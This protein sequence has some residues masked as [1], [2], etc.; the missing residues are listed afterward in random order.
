MTYD[1]LDE[2]TILVKLTQAPKRACF[3]FKLTNQVKDLVI[4]ET[5][6]EKIP[7]NV[8]LP[9]TYYRLL[10]LE[11][12]YEIKLFSASPIKVADILVIEHKFNQ[13]L[14]NATRRHDLVRASEGKTFKDYK[15]ED[16]MTSQQLRS[17]YR[18]N[19]YRV[20]KAI[21]TQDKDILN[22]ALT[23][24]QE[25]NAY[26]RKIESYTGNWWDYE[27]G[28][29]KDILRQIRL[30]YEFMDAN[31]IF[32]LLDDIYR[33][34]PNYTY[35]I[36]RHESKSRELAKGANYVDVLEI[37]LW[38]K[39]FSG[40]FR[41][42]NIAHLDL[43]EETDYVT[44]GNGVYSDG[45]FVDHNYVPYT[46]SYGEVYLKGIIKIIV[47]LN[48]SGI[49]TDLMN[50]RIDHYIR[51]GFIPFMYH[52][53]VFDS[54]RGRAIARE[55]NS[56]RYI[57]NSFEQIFNSFYDATKM[58]RPSYL[59]LGNYS[60]DRM[61]RF[62][63]K[64]EEYSLSL[65]LASKFIQTHECINGENLNGWY[66]GLGAINYHFRDFDL[67]RTGYYPTVNSKFVPGVTNT[68]IDLASDMDG[69][70]IE[71]AIVYRVC[72]NDNCAITYIYDSPFDSLSGA[73]SYYYL[74]DVLHVIGSDIKYDGDEHL[75]HTISNFPF[76]YSSRYDT[77]DNNVDI[78][79]NNRT[80][81]YEVIEGNLKTAIYEK[82]A[83]Y[84]DININESENPYHNEFFLSYLD[85]NG[86]EHP[87]YYYRFK[88]VNVNSEFS[89]VI[90]DDYHYIKS[91]SGN[92]IL[93]IFK[94]GVT[95]QLEGR[96]YK[97]KGLILSEKGHVSQSVK[98]IIEAKTIKKEER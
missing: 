30:M 61:K 2:T 81:R 45:S 14:L 44:S 41:K 84:N 3:S 23:R 28:I 67:Y 1:Y 66:Y 56:S 16:Y 76:T 69:L 62:L 78:I 90:T 10:D 83:S 31:L 87:Q 26:Y 32:E 92:F 46:G 17:A 39:Y 59:V 12:V 74:D 60:Y 91:N 85:L 5:K 68:S 77:Y 6:K 57:H 95:V 96:E 80:Y 82:R 25:L 21:L 75:R 37:N 55:L 35:I 34:V 73:Y 97:N 9:G 47:L 86:T 19:A 94:D 53:I 49:K 33:M 70:R 51:T 42:I 79:V 89:Y 18:A 43:Y 13:E 7:V 65:S 54:V 98:G 63:V 4:I 64:R 36:N 8:C 71:N 15:L 72:S 20:H 48:V 27:I 38:R 24:L 40:D 22:E 88:D 29:P 52:G 50:E 11:D 58:E 93:S